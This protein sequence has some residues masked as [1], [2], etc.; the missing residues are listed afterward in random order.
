MFAERR[1]MGRHRPGYPR[2]F[3]R[4]GARHHVRM[5]AGK[6][7]CNPLCQTPYHG[8]TARQTDAEFQSKCVYLI[9]GF[10]ALAYQ[11]VTDP[12]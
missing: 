1:L 9:G 3:I 12:V 7:L 8:N 2:Q 10:D 5:M 4:Q 11:G 6:L